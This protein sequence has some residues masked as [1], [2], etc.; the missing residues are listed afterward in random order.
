MRRARLRVP[1]GLGFRMRSRLIVAISMTLVFVAGVLASRYLFAPAAFVY[2]SSKT[3]RVAT[4]LIPPRIL[5]D[6]RLV[7]QSSQSLTKSDLAGQWTLVFMGFTNCGDVCPATLYKLSETVKKLPAPPRVLF[8]SVDPGRD[9]PEIIG[10]YLRGFNAG[11]AGA[12]GTRN[13]LTRF[14]EGLSAPYQVSTHDGR[15]IV[16]HS[17]AVFLLDPAAQLRAVFSAPHD[18]EAIAEDLVAITNSRA[19]VKIM[20]SKFY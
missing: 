6:F 20:S 13:E 18:P 16:D 1:A 8:V 3:T 17:S 4:V 5:P 15:Y 10:R 7:N 12:T 11:F 14:A 9:S 19:A 2:G